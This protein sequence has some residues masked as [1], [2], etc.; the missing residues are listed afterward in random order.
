[1]ASAAEDIVTEIVTLL[2]VPALVSVPASRVFRDVI[3]ARR[4]ADMPCIAVEAGDEDAPARSLIGVK[5]RRLQVDVTVLA[6]GVTPYAQADAVLVESHNRIFGAQT[7][8]GMWLNGL[9]LDVIEGPTRRAR[10]GVSDD[11]A[12]ITKTYVIAYR[13]AERSIERL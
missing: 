9:A 4:V 10:D 5:D 13:T 7:L 11:V 1:M 3:D 8:S 2:T 6:K 12:A